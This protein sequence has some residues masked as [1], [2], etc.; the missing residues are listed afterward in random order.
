MLSAL[1][2]ESTTTE[3]TNVSAPSDNPTTDSSVPSTAQLDNSLT[4]LLT[5]VHAL[6]D[7]T[8]TEISVSSVMVDKLGI[9]TLTPVSAPLEASGTDTPALTPVVEEESL[10]PL[11]DSVSAPPETGMEEHALSAQI[12]KSGAAQ[13]SP[14]YALKETGT[15]SPVSFAL[16]TKSGSLQL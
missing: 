5:L 13:D 11:A 8:G 10:M 15:D 14:V 2:A 1:E 12:L 4:K 7:K 16:Q 3:P 6:E 9:R